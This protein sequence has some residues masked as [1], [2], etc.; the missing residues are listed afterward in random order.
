MD[1]ENSCVQLNIFEY[2]GFF[3]EKVLLSQTFEQ[4]CIVSAQIFP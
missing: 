2:L 1:V 3:G 4:L